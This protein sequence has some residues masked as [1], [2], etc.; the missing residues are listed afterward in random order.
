[1]SGIILGIA[2]G[3]SD[4]TATFNVNPVAAGAST[5]VG[6]TYTF[7]GYGAAGSVITGTN[8][9]AAHF[10]GAAFGTASPPTI[11]GAPIIGVFSV[12]TDPGTTGTVFDVIVAGDFSALTNTVNTFS[13]G[14]TNVSTGATKSVAYVATNNATR[15][16]FTQ[17]VALASPFLPDGGSKQVIIT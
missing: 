8:T 14:G 12:Y 13:I 11:N 15:F 6:N 2:A 17:S 7:H 1:M 3:F 5:G 16:T 4:A 10:P 9:F